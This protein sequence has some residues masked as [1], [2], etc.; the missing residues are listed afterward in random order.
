MKPLGWKSA[1]LA[2][3]DAK[4]VYKNLLKPCLVSLGTHVGPK[5]S[6]SG[7][8]VCSYFILFETFGGDMWVYAVTS[9]LGLQFPDASQHKSHHP[10]TAHVYICSPP[11]VQFIPPLLCLTFKWLVLSGSNLAKCPFLCQRM[12]VFVCTASESISAT[13]F[14]DCGMSMNWE[15]SYHLRGTR[16]REPFEGYPWN[17]FW[18][19][20]VFTFLPS[21]SA[22]PHS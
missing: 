8:L 13:H 22:C 18:F 6:L 16:W 7:I 12:S 15:W 2:A 5:S 1:T 19:L 14:N 10:D 4:E 20:Q 11:W 9:T 3:T 17:H 21:S